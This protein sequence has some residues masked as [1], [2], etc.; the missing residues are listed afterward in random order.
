MIHPMINE[1]RTCEECRH[2]TICIVK[3][4]LNLN[5]YHDLDTA[6]IYNNLTHMFIAV[7][8]CCTIYSKRNE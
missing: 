7:A 8:N 2:D 6:D 4:T 1:D 3:S 5:L